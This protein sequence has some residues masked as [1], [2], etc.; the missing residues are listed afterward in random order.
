MNYV[1]G[2]DIERY[3][4]AGVV[5]PDHA[6]RTKNWP[7]IV[8]PPA[9]GQ[10]DDFKRGAQAA[11]EI[12]DA[13]GVD[14]FEAIGE[15]DMFDCE[16]WSLE[17][18]KLGKAPDKPLA[19]Q[20]A[21]VTGAAGAIGSAVARVFAT[22]GAAVALLDIDREKAQVRA[23]EI[24]GAAIAIACDV[25]D[26]ASVRAAFDRAVETFGGI[27]IVVSNAGGAF[28]GRIGEVD[29]AVLR[30][31]SCSRRAPAAACC[32][33]CRNRRSIPAPISALMDCPRRRRFC[34]CGN[35]RSNMARPASAPMRS[36]PT[37][38]AR[39]S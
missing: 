2:A 28:T 33:M 6:I 25:T 4:Q 39:A 5:T 7:L 16:Y 24:G 38:S 8:P 26:A 30:Q 27:D 11:V 29:E 15:A 17:Q 21:V 19:G 36:T 34:S 18:A 1:N 22:A 14:R 23:R 13:E 20:I 10:S 37:A 32:S 9:A 35:T 12:T 31:S 3:S